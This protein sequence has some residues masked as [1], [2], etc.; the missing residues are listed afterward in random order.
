MEEIRDLTWIA[1]IS[2]EGRN[3]IT[4]T[5][6]EGTG[7]TSNVRITVSEDTEYSTA[8]SGMVTFICTSCK[9]ERIMYEVPVCRCICDCDR[10]DNVK[11]VVFGGRVETDMPES[12]W[13]TTKPIGTYEI[14]ARCGDKVSAVLIYHGEELPECDCN[15]LYVWKQ[16]EPQPE[17]PIHTDCIVTDW[18]ST[19]QQL[20]CEGGNIYLT[21]EICGNELLEAKE[22]EVIM[23]YDNINPLENPNKN[24]C[25]G[26]GFTFKQEGLLCECDLL[27]VDWYDFSIPIV[28]LSM[29]TPLGTYSISKEACSKKLTGYVTQTE[30]RSVNIPLSFSENKILLGGD[31]SYNNIQSD[32]EYNFYVV[33]EG[34]TTECP[35]KM[36][37]QPHCKCSNLV[38][39]NKVTE[40]PVTG[41]TAGTP[42][43][44]YSTT[45]GCEM[46][47]KG[48]IDGVDLVFE[49]GSVKLGADIGRNVETA[50]TPHNVTISYNGNNGCDNFTITQDACNCV[51]IDQFTPNE[52]KLSNDGVEPPYTFATY[53][54][55]GDCEYNLIGATITG[56]IFA[57]EPLDVST[58][59]QINL[60]TPIPYNTG[61]T[62]TYTIN[63]SFNGI[64]CKNF[65]VDQKDGTPCGCENITIDEP[66]INTNG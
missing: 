13:P 41:F 60:L 25:E 27:N 54:I 61:S 8:T 35:H 45:E 55:T 10:L 3:W 37:V 5:P 15:Y 64:N 17:P 6:S 50:E 62:I 33:F 21:K 51:K 11:A 49:G 16:G 28:G 36:V 43:A 44:T 2:S 7:D 42:I 56:G 14:S 19:Q 46:P 20:R 53:T 59:G 24:K 40:M 52:T 4:V 22:F 38:I 63:V 12:G 47:P 65:D 34:S 9:K 48:T 23:Y 26:K 29:G 18:G 66:I 32:R 30:R 57:N 31:I 58:Y 1:Q 39:S